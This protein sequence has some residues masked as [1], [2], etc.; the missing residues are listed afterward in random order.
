LPTTR[1][2]IAEM[3]AP[4]EVSKFR[5]AFDESFA[6]SPFEPIASFAAANDTIEF[7][8]TTAVPAVARGRR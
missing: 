6:L 1:R 8:K 5:H 7:T 2:F 3:A 4:M